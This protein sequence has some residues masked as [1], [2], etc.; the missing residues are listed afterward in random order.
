MFRDSIGSASLVL[1]KSIL[2]FS[3]LFSNF[4]GEI[5]IEFRDFRLDGV[6]L[7]QN[8]DC[9]TSDH[10]VV[11]QKI[12]NLGWRQVRR[13]CGDWNPRLK[14]IHVV[15]QVSGLRIRAFLAPMHKN[16]EKPRGFVAKVRETTTSHA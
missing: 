4:S 3:F 7:G 15:T 5:A 6:D 1:S 14:A 2:H 12:R 16:E 8:A 11:E 13:Y 10:L 9:L